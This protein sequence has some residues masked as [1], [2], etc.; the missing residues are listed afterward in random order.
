MPTMRHRDDQHVDQQ[1]AVADPQQLVAQARP[2]RRAHAGALPCSPGRA[3][4]R[5]DRGSC[6]RSLARMRRTWVSMVRS[7]MRKSSARTR[8]MIW[9]RLQ[10]RPGRS[11]SAR[12]M[13]NS[14]TV[15]STGV[16]STRGSWARQI[17]RQA[18]VRH[19]GRRARRARAARRPP[20][21]RLHPRR[22]LAR[23]EGLGHVVVAAELQAEDAI[24]LL[25]PRRQEDDRQATA[26]GAQARGTPPARRARA[27]G[28]RA[29]PGRRRRR[30]RAA[31]ASTPSRAVTTACPS[32]SR[33][34][35][36]TSRM[37]ASS[38]T[39]RMVAIVRAGPVSAIFEHLRGC[40][41]RR[42]GREPGARGAARA[43]PLLQELA[44]GLDPGD[45][46]AH[47]LLAGGVARAHQAQHL[48]LGQQRARRPSTSSSRRAKRSRSAPSWAVSSG[49]DPGPARTASISC[50]R[51]A[52][53]CTE[54]PS[55]R[56]AAR[57]GRRRASGV[58]AT[59]RSARASSRSRVRAARPRP[60]AEPAEGAVER[61][62]QH[63][64]APNPA[65]PPRRPAIAPATAQA[66]RPAV[67]AKSAYGERG[68]AV[69]PAHLRSGVVDAAGRA[70]WSG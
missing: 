22:Q 54:R 12:R 58:P 33:V 1:Q 2:P 64:E 20:Q 39:T 44:Q 61:P 3:R 60:P 16:P 63:Q 9:A 28:C 15:S 27:S 36:T 49:V 30:R 40:F 25:G 50:T 21:H 69:H 41:N 26:V 65:G 23:G 51:A 4:S 11:S 56:T 67:D 5:W 46:L 18:A 37:W 45:Q 38:S 66:P 55:A 42:E 29:P 35:C 32:R 14:V 17:Q 19:A 24:H 59:R 70:A 13:A 68:R 48:D 34:Y 8:A 6:A 62:Q 31:S 7:V 43:R 57:S 10:T 53:A 47:Q 52:A